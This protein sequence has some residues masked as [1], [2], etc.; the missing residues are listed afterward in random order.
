MQRRFRGARWLGAAA[1]VVVVTIALLVGYLAAAEGWVQFGRKAPPTP[2]SASLPDIIDGVESSAVTIDSATLDGD[3]FGSGFVVATGGVVLTNA[4]VV[5]HS[6][7]LTVVDRDGKKY[8][9]H[10]IGLD[11]A[12]D[13]AEVKAEG[14]DRA[15]LKLAAGSATVKPG[16]QIY[17]VGN[18]GGTHPNSVL[19]GV[20]SA[21]GIDTT[22]EG[23]DYHGLYQLDT[24]NVVFGNSGSPIITADGTV[25]GMDA[26]YTLQSAVST[27]F[28]YAIPVATFRQEA[29]DWSTLTS[30]LA[31][32]P[33]DLPWQTDP[34]AAVVQLRELARGYAL[35]AEAATQ[36]SGSGPYPPSDEVTFVLP[37]NATRPSHRIFSRVIVYPL[38]YNATGEL[39]T[40]HNQL[41]ESAADEV[42]QA[43]LGD[44][45]Y[46]FAEPS[47]DGSTTVVTVIW[48]DRNV[49][50]RIQ[51]DGLS[52]SAAVQAAYALASGV[53]QRV[54]ASPTINPDA[55]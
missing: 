30:P 9:A 2:H 31:G 5:A 29:L 6:F 51:L 35:T 22:V 48:R 16:T 8:L 24:A 37:A 42:Q 23:V 34:K 25:I 50:C 55:P 18:P 36:F 45:S 32:D 28:A 3:A 12:N 21:T 10:V 43:T 13:V 17:V 11:R 14:L 40:E 1:V 15:P 4:H 19:Q 39:S 20:V 7:R 38:R 53:E 44:Q 49:M 26:L 52:G 33:H 46:F 27:R 54:A 41:A 47:R